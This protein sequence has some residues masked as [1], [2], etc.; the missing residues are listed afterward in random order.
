VVVENVQKGG[1]PYFRPRVTKD[2]AE[3]P[4]FIQMMKQC[5]DQD[6]AS[7]PKFSE[8]LKFLKQMNKGK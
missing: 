8:C 3:H 2:L 1:T 7:R 6:A 4:L 5:W